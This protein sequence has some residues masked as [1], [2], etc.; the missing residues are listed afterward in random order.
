MQLDFNWINLLI[1]FGAIQGLIFCLILLFNKKHPG[2]KFLSIF[3]FAIAYN[4]FETFNW[5]AG[6]DKYILLFDIL[7]FVVIFCVGPSLYLYVTSLLYPNQKFSTKTILSHFAIVGFQFFFRSFQVIA[8]LVWMRHTPEGEHT[9]GKIESF[10]W[11]YSEPLSIV[12]F[13]SYLIASIKIFRRTKISGNQV[14]AISKEGRQITHN[15]LRALLTCMVIMALGWPTTVIASYFTEEVGNAYYPI[16]VLLVLF[17]YWIAYAGYHKTMLI[18][19]SQK[20]KTTAL[21]TEDVESMFAQLQTIMETEKMHLDAEL[22]LAKVASRMAVTPKTISAILNQYRQT[23]FND[24]V[25]HYRVEDIKLKLVDP[26][27]QHM[28]IAGIALETGFNSQATFQRAFKSCTGLSPS[29]YINLHKKDLNG[30]IH[31]IK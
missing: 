3:M 24:F 9:F 13:V 15:W 21:Q 11:L 16:E 8:Y 29:Q 26:Q 19:A 17:I 12:V 5:S 22:N 28:T 6:L 25:N 2:A 31:A 7:P 14:S 27:F 10:Y 20:S 23:N 4:G 1:L 30:K 18:Y